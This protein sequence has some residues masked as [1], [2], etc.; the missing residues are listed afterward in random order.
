MKDGLTPLLVGVN[1]GHVA[2]CRF[3]VGNGA[4]PDLKDDKGVSPVV[5]AMMKKEVAILKILLEKGRHF[6]SHI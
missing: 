3:L 5:L 1:E 6:T 2:L 4:D